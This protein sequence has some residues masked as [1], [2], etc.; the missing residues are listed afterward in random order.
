MSV[1]TDA[2]GRIKNLIKMFTRG[3]LPVFF[4]F[5]T[6]FG[7]IYFH[8]SKDSPFQAEK[9]L[10]RYTQ[11]D[12]RRALEK[13][14]EFVVK[15][16]QMEQGITVAD[17]EIQ[18]GYMYFKMF[19]AGGLGYFNAKKHPAY[20]SILSAV[21]NFNDYARVYTLVQAYINPKWK[22]TKE[23]FNHQW[24]MHAYDWYK[25][26]QSPEQTEMNLN[27]THGFQY[28]VDRET[29]K[30]VALFKPRLHDEKNST[31][32]SARN[33]QRMIKNEEIQHA[34]FDLAREMNMDNFLVSGV[35]TSF[36]FGNKT[37]SGMLEPFYELCVEKQCAKDSK[38]SLAKESVLLSRNQ[39]RF[40]TICAG[41][42]CDSIK[43]FANEQ[44]LYK[45]KSK[46]KPL[47]IKTLL[48]QET[49]AGS[50]LLS[51]LM[52]QQ[53]AHENN[54][55][56]IWDSVVEKF[57]VRALDFE[58]ALNLELIKERS[59]RSQNPRAEMFLYVT[60]QRSVSEILKE[61][62]KGWN[63]LYLEYYLKLYDLSEQSKNAFFERLRKVQNSFSLQTTYYDFFDRILEPLEK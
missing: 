36:V 6:C 60:K 47:R 48:D 58:D 30:T 21:K 55:L 34:V 14:I 23:E 57:K 7:E 59:L 41:N 4:F 51:Y 49:L 22:P 8:P 44:K 53:D 38:T 37:V 10:M 52:A 15:N 54:Y 27:L 13:N 45:G 50:I 18:M 43:K 31:R 35:S 28:F 62:I 40:G 63:T 12:Y 17:K 2:T 11:H 9:N 33:T 16:T 39:F 32:N 1:V 5:Q 24:Y 56:T 19:E 25:A 46:K 26:A 42:V 20:H 29:K 3:F 61:K